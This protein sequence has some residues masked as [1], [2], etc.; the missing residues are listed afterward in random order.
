MSD[1][2]FM[3]VYVCEPQTNEN[4]NLFSK[5]NFQVML[6]KSLSW[7][8]PNIYAHDCNY[9][10]QTLFV[11]AAA[12]VPNCSIEFSVMWWSNDEKRWENP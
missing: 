6:K 8:L 2:F 9:V 5:I 11:A 3:Y 10:V 12:N 1:I 4:Q 7:F